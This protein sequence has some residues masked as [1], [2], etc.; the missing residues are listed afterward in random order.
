M[1]LKLK[2]ALTFFGEER[3]ERKK[4]LYACY[5][6]CNFDLIQVTCH[7]KI[8]NYSKVLMSIKRRGSGRKKEIKKK[9]WKDGRM[10]EINK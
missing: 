6:L 10:I 5:H 9:E 8:K 1:E 7:Q 2:I 4:L 3:K